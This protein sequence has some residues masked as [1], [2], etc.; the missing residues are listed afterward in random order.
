MFISSSQ[1]RFPLNVFYHNSYSRRIFL[2]PWRINYSNHKIKQT[3]EIYDCDNH[4]VVAQMKEP[5]M[6]FVIY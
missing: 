1:I 4:L 3:W 6:S 5:A 2:K